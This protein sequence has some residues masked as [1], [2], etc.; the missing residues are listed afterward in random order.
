MKDLDKKTKKEQ[1]IINKKILK[2]TISN[3]S[4]YYQI[5][6]DN[7]N[8]MEDI[9]IDPIFSCEGL[10]IFEN[11]LNFRKELEKNIYR[12]LSYMKL[13]IPFSYEELNEE[14]YTQKL[15]EYICNK[16]NEDIRKSFNECIKRQIGQK[17]NQ[18]DLIKKMFKNEGRVKYN[19]KDIVSIIHEELSTEYANYLAQFYFNAEKDNFFATLLSIEEDKKMNVQKKEDILLFQNNTKQRYFSEFKIEKENKILKK[20]GQNLINI[21]LGLKIPKIMKTIK[22]LINF[23]KDEI[24]KEYLKNEYNNTKRKQLDESLCVKINQINELKE[25]K[26]KDDKKA[27]TE[28]LE[29]LLED[30]YTIFIFENMKNLKEKKGNEKKGKYIGINEVKNFLKYLVVLKEKE[31]SEEEN[32]LDLKIAK[33]IN[34]IQC[35]KDEI[36]TILQMFSTLGFVGIDLKSKIINKNIIEQEQNNESESLSIAI[37][38]LYFGVE[39][40][41]R[42]LT[43]DDNIYISLKKKSEDFYELMNIN[44]EILQ[45]AFK[46]EASL[47]FSIKE[48]FSLKEIIEIIDSLQKNKL[49]TTDNIKETIKYFKEQ[50]DLMLDIDKNQQEQQELINKFKEFYKFLEGVFEKSEIFPKLISSIFYDEY[51]KISNYNFR[52]ELLDKISSKNEYIYHCYPLLKQIIKSKINSKDIDGN[53]KIITGKTEKILLTLSKKKSEFLDLAIL[54]IFEQIFLEFFESYKKKNEKDY[55]KCIISDEFLKRFDKYVSELN[56]LYNSENSEENSNSSYLSILYYI[57]YIKVYLTKFVEMI[58]KYDQA[59]EIPLILEKIKGDKN[60]M[61]VI[62]LYIVKILYNLMNKNWEETNKYDFIKDKQF[63]NEVL[64]VDGPSSFSEY[65]LTNYFMPLGYNNEEEFKKEINVFLNAIKNSESSEYSEIFSGNKNIKI[66]KFLTIAINKILSNLFSKYYLESEEGQIF[67]NLCKYCEKYFEEFIDNTQLKNLLNLFCNKKDFLEK[68]K[69]K[70]EEQYKNKSFTGHPYE[71]L[72][73][74]LRFCAQSLLKINENDQKYFYSSILSKESL[75]I[76]NGSLIPGNNALKNKKLEKFNLLKSAL[77]KSSDD[78]GIYV[79]SCGYYYSIEPCGFPTK[80]HS[81][82]CLDCKLPIGYGEK[83]IKNKGESNHG[84]VIRPG[85]YR[86]FKNERHKR[87]QM[88]RF[89]EPDENI[90]NL[91]LEQYKKNIIDPIS[92]SVQKGFCKIEKEDFLDKNKTTRNIDIISYRLLNFI[93]FNHIF[94]ANCLGYISDIDLEKNFLINGMNC[95]EIIQ[96]NWNILEE[97]LNEI[98]ISSI[99]AFMNLILKDISELISNC[100]II[101]DKNELIQF[102]KNIE[103]IIFINFNKYLGYEKKYSRMNEELNSIDAKNIK[104]IINEYFPPEKYSKTDFPLLNYFMYTKYDIDFFNALKQEKDYMSRYPLL[105]NYLNYLNNSE[106]KKVKYLKYLRNFNDFT[107]TMVETYSYHITRKEA[108]EI[109]LVNSN[110]YNESKFKSFSDSWEHIY[111]YAIKYKCREVMPEKQLKSDDPLIYFLNDDNELGYGMYI[112]AA[113]QNF[114]NWQN[115]FLQP[116]IENE[117]FNGNLRY[118]IEN[119]KKKIPVQ[120]ANPNQILSI[121]DCFK[122]SGYKDFN[123][124]INTFTK[125]NIYSENK[126]DYQKYNK[127]IIDFSKIEEELGKLILPE[128]CLFENED[129]LNFVIFWGEGFRGGQS[130]TILKFY[131]KYPQVDLKEDE[132]EKIYSD[133]RKFYQ[134]KNYDFKNFFGSMQLLMFFLVNNTFSPDT[135]LNHIL[136]NK[137]EYLNLDDKFVKFFDDYDFKIKQFMDIFFYA[138]H[139][140]FQELIKTLQPEYKKE[141]DKKV[142]EDIKKKFQIK[143][144]NDELPWKELAA[145]IRR[146]IS[147]YLV[148]ERQTT[149]IDESLELALQLT[150][151]DLWGEIFGKLENF[152]SLIYGKINEF[153]LKV[154]QAFNLYEIIG[155]EDKNTIK[156]IEKVEEVKKEENIQEE[157]KNNEVNAEDDVVPSEEEDEME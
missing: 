75:S 142:I 65:F 46:L 58:D 93:L 5:F 2:E 144:E 32:K 131:E 24:E 9:K 129:N 152:E 125:R 48:A 81:S 109:N 67:E 69:P 82:I 56:S 119:M 94:F 88:A 15:I 23:I 76:L 128:K 112:A 139:L 38:P 21:Y 111:K 19:D 149:D 154:G 127:F 68:L 63:Q 103:Q 45:C 70:F 50:T 73:Y 14:N 33:I 43:S 96:S 27:E 101:E 47:H 91:T 22:G 74:G 36:T 39:S 60:L 40:I 151:R 132:R 156:N 59:S 114:I 20:Q 85:H 66:D 3:L 28:L 51:L 98:N 78:E 113:C 35:Y 12:I 84:M 108:K 7:L 150:R 123:D 10:E 134:N 118:Y 64:Y 117:K 143:V 55:E 121:D 17:D 62:K 77:D 99:Q 49:D 107:N 79:C 42:V 86:I 133:F 8:G 18:Y 155:E 30:Y 105:Y 147:R 130:D 89:D 137:P 106:K 29:A 44:K 100:K 13:N 115:G 1:K 87:E 120:E 116:I 146:F 57:A 92:N 52:N 16:E 102:E 122:N 34:W 31:N 141:I 138:E 83:K 110:N 135:D 41:L 53:L 104:V 145:A 126:I 80:E 157:D 136:K 97:A 37:N 4:E 124:L 26:K 6:I 71:S 140:S 61:R 95:L 153:K 90:P 54:Q 148:G 72:L 25:I 11:F